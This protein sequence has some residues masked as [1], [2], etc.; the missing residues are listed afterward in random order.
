MTERGHDARAH[1]HPVSRRDGAE[2]IPDDEHG[3]QAHQRGFAGHFCGNDGENRRADR[4]P[5]RVARDEHAG[6][7]YRYSEIACDVGQQAHDDEFGRADTERGNGE[8]EEGK[9]HGTE[10]SLRASGKRQIV[11][12]GAAGSCLLQFCIVGNRLR[13]S[14]YRSG[15]FMKIWGLAVLFLSTVAMAQGSGP[16]TTKSGVVQFVQQGD[17]IDV[18]LDGVSIDRLSARRV[19][20]F[21]EPS[22]ARML[23]EVFNAGAPELVLYDFGRRPPLVEKI[24]RRMSLSGVFWQPDEVVMRSTDGWFRFQ[25][26]VLTKL[27]SSKV[28]YH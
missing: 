9:G 8:G 22:G 5:E 17:V 13:R 1:Q 26:G 6:G 19:A 15:A 20:H 10:K 4:H 24:G 7:G 27:S 3:D 12:N 21:E 11:P 28:V 18:Q 16:V 25:R 14:R 23:V 2:K